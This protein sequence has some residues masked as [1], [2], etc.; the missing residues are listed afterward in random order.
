MSSTEPFGHSEDVIKAI[1]EE[2]RSG[3]NASTIAKRRRGWTNGM[4]RGVITRHGAVYG[5]VPRSEAQKALT[6]SLTITAMRKP[7]QQRG[8]ALKAV[9]AANSRLPLTSPRPEGLPANLRELPADQML[10]IPFHAIETHRQC[11]WPVGEPVDGEFR[12]CGR[13]RDGRYCEEHNRISARQMPADSQK[14]FER[15][16]RRYL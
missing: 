2:W 9:L 5:A 3:D 7:R 4:V 16:L 11:K 14:E 8:A 1:C 6:Q 10:L 12:C 13:K 15:G